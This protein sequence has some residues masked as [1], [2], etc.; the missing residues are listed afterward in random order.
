MCLLT[1]R[2]AL[3]SLGQK[4]K[5]I[6]KSDRV[7]LWLHTSCKPHKNRSS[8]VTEANLVRSIESSINYLFR[9]LKILDALICLSVCRDHAWLASYSH[10]QVDVVLGFWWDLPLINHMSTIEDSFVICE[11]QIIWRHDW[12]TQLY[13][14]LKQGRECVNKKQAKRCITEGE[15]WKRLLWVAEG[16]WQENNNNKKIKTLETQKHALLNKKITRS[17]IHSDN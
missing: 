16:M 2:Q 7:I 14:Q 5:W 15:K 1:T 11:H 4:N 17:L 8:V 13:T 12:S 6:S 3:E 10:S 9:Q